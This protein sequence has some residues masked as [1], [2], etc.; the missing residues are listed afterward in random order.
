MHHWLIAALVTLGLATVA[1]RHLYAD[2]A[3]TAPSTQPATQPAA[4]AVNKFC[5]VQK[6]NPV[7]DRVPTVTY[8]GKVIGFCCPDCREVFLRNPEQYMEDLK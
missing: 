5:P 2:D 7:D 6:D 1:A 8:D 4:V 3:T